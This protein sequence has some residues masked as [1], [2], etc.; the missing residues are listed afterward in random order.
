MGLKMT[1][2]KENNSLYCD[3]V[4]AYWAI[5]SVMH[6]IETVSFRLVA[7]PSRDAKLANQFTQVNPTLGFGRATYKMVDSE[8]YIMPFDAPAEDIFPNGIPLG[9]DAQYTAIYTWIKIYTQL[10]FEDVFELEL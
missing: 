1:L 7:Y 5:D 8:L 4:D 3:F 9:K 10:P 6:G 2:S